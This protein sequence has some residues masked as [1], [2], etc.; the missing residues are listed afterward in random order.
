LPWREAEAFADLARDD[1][2]E[3]GR[4]GDNAHARFRRVSP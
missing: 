2:L 4:D 3:F 1:D